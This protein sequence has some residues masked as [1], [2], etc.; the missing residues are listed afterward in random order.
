MM[1]KSEIAA[2]LGNAAFFVFRAIGIPGDL[3]GFRY[4]SPRRIGSLTANTPVFL[5]ISERPPH[6]II[7]SRRARRIH[8]RGG[9]KPAVSEDGSCSHKEML[10]GA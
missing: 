5:C 3:R 6:V 10:L 9:T 8:F 1:V 2:F 4:M 7:E